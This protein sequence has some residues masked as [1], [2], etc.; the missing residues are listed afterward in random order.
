MYAVRMQP[1]SHTL[2][3]RAATVAIGDAPAVMGAIAC[4]LAAAI[5]YWCFRALAL[6]DDD[7][8]VGRVSSPPRVLATRSTTDLDIATRG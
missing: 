2:R 6:L 8:D 1:R 4:V 5:L 3:A 7:I